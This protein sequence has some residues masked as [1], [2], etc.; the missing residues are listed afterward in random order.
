MSATLIRRPLAEAPTFEQKLALTLLAMDDRLNVAGVE[1]AVRAAGHDI[2]EILVA[3]LPA[4]PARYGTP[5]AAILQQA[6]QLMLTRGWCRRWLTNEDGAVCLLGAIR[7]AGGGSGERRQAEELLLDL[8]RREFPD[9]TSISA[10]NDGQQDG[11][12]ALRMLDRA[13]RH[14]DQHGI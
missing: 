6:H 12:P 5:V 7:A 1:A 14:A 13:A 8:V 9:A 4:E 3:P 11:R 2:P 10:W